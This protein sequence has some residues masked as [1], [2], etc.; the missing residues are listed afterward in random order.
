M[1][2]SNGLD[3]HLFLSTDGKDAVHEGRNGR[4]GVFFSRQSWHFS[5]VNDM[6]KV[7]I[8]ICT[9]NWRVKNYVSRQGRYK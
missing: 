7:F 9:L 5:S 2:F 4:K 8:H 3:L 1:S 6:I